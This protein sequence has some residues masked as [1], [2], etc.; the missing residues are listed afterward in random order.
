MTC[1]WLRHIESL[2]LVRN[3]GV[4][5]D[6]K[7][8][9]DLHSGKVTTRANQWIN[10][11]FRNFVRKD[12]AFLKKCYLSYVRPILEYCSPVW[13]PHLKKDIEALERV[14]KYFTRRVHGLKRFDYKE[15]LFILNLESLEEDAFC[16]LICIS[17]WQCISKLFIIWLIWT[18]MISLYG[19]SAGT[20]AGSQFQVRIKK[21]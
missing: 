16:I 20:N 8:N 5:I 6:S 12:P 21:V 17:I 14:Q 11:I 7:L 18:L 15:R 13:S 4:E 1:R 3:L 9:F 19:R 10:L 2:D